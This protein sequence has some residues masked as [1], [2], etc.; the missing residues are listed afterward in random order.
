MCIRDRGK[1]GGPPPHAE[2]RGGGDRRLPFDDLLERL[3]WW[4]ELFELPCVG[5]AASLD[6]VGPL[7]ATGADFIALGEWIWNEPQGVAAS[8][9]AAAEILAAPAAR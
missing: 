5:Y 6:E 1:G 9:A 7:V 3:T 8:V 4:A 2:A